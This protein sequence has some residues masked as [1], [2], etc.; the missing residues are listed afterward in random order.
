MRAGTALR[1]QGRLDYGA[2]GDLAGAA[3]HSGNLDEARLLRCVYGR[4]Q[5]TA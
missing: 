4:G 1:A 5:F 3:L 2:I